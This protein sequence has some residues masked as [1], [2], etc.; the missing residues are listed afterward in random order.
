MLHAENSYH[1]EN[2]KIIGRPCKTNIHPATAFRGFGGPQGIFA[3]ESVIERIA[4]TLGLDPYDVRMKNMYHKGDLAPYGQEIHH[5]EDIGRILEK[6][7]TDSRWDERKKEIAAFNQKNRYVKKGLGITPVKFGISF[8]AAHLNQGS[9]LISV[10]TDGSVSVTHGAIE[11][12][13]EVNTKIAQIA[14]TT[15]GIP[16]GSIRIESNN[17]KRVANT[18]A[19]AASSGC[20]LNGHAVEN[21]ALKILGRLKEL[22]SKLYPGEDVVLKTV[23]SMWCMRE[24]PIMR[25][26]LF[27]LRSWYKKH[28][29]SGLIYAI[30]GITQL[31]AFILTGIK[32]KGIHFYIMCLEQQLQ[33]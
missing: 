30:T 33:K 31:P 23:M 8:T 1:I 10:Y 6:L 15:L 5:G 27:R 13:Q 21:A 9:A 3:I 11:M 28:I 17:T 25:I 26:L 4:Y 7:R 12:G 24:K 20:D 22:V 19:T 16:I 14:A 2:I 18:S 29:L 32:E